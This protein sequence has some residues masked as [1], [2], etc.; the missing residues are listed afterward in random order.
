MRPLWRIYIEKPRKVQKTLLI[1]ALQY[2]LKNIIQSR[3]KMRT[4]IKLHFQ[5]NLK[6]KHI[7]WDLCKTT[8]LKPKMTK[9]QKLK[10]IRTEK[11]KQQLFRFWTKIN[12]NCNNW[13]CCTEQ[14]TIWNILTM[15]S[16]AT[17]VHLVR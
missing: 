12:S 1:M 17:Q 11:I 2:W 10:I 3:L 4:R 9:F 7:K 15:A 8:R 14:H 6:S 16:V 13:V 5:R